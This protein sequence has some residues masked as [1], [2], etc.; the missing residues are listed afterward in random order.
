MG[1]STKGLLDDDMSTESTD[2]PTGVRKY[3]VFLALALSVLIVGL[4]ASIVA[5]ANPQITNT[6]D[7]LG[8]VGW[9]GSAY[10]LTACTCQLAYGKMYQLFP[11]KWVFLSG[12]AIFEIGSLVSAL[13]PTSSAFIA[14][15][16]VS[17]L[18]FAGIGT[19][20]LIII[21]HS[22][23]LEQRPLFTGIVGAMEGIGFIVGPLLGGALTTTTTWRWCFWINLPVGAVTA[24]VVGFLLKP[25]RIETTATLTGT[26][27]QKLQQFDWAG[28]LTF[29][30]SILCLLL[31]L[32]WGGSKFSWSDPRIIVLFILFGLLLVAF[33]GIQVYSAPERATLPA[34]VVKSR[35]IIFGAL[36]AFSLSASLSIMSF[37]LPL[38]FQGIKNA[39]ALE[40]G[41]MLLPIILGM[42]VG[43]I[44]G[45]VL[46]T[47]IG[48]YPPMMV[49]SGILTAVASGLFTTFTPDTPQ[50]RWIGYLALAG[51]GA[52]LG[53]QQ[54][55]LAAQTVLAKQDVAAGT[56]LMIFSQSL[57]GAV[58]IAV[59]NS[60]FL[61]DLLDGLRVAFPGI[62]PEMILELGA[63]N[64]KG[65]IPAQMLDAVL[66]AYN[67][68][69]AKTFYAAVA[70][71][72]FAFFLSFGME[73]RLVKKKK[74]VAGEEGAEG[75]EP[76]QLEEMSRQSVERVDGSSLREE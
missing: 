62:Q 50:P 13:A 54:P 48:Y 64:L 18:G 46:V 42:A 12:I 15:R 24:L 60:I 7:S 28:T 31:A 52:G 53:F 19:G 35:S 75:S 27:W 23:P 34:Q 47:L 29:V 57:A 14:S 37:Y 32:Q 9:Y 72:G 25:P 45:A 71:A 58:F 3:V 74:K 56:S 76:V 20:A 43:S 8:D 59:G 41:I 39:T 69:I 65:E 4:D 49:I 70:T 33:A 26:A 21:A 73:M 68:A 61:N 67:H 30:P 40:S 1:K 51:L 5:T 55:L 36:F 22:A 38:W 16:A 6:F 10:L 44:L 11:I 66:G 2:Y 63:T 17:G